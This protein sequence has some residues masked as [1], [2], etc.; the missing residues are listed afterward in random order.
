MLDYIP[1]AHHK[2]NAQHIML[3]Q[4]N[5]KLIV[6]VAHNVH[7]LLGRSSLVIILHKRQFKVSHLPITFIP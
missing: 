2:F 1:F 7:S 4:I 3:V 6:M 5:L